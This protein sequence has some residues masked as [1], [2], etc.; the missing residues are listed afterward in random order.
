VFTL[1][2]DQSY[3]TVNSILFFIFLQILKVLLLEIWIE[4]FFEEVLAHQAFLRSFLQIQNLCHLKS[5]SLKGTSE[6]ICFLWNYPFHPI[7]LSQRLIC[8]CKVSSFNSL[9][10][11]IFD[12]WTVTVLQNIQNLVRCSLEHWPLTWFFK[13]ELRLQNLMH[14]WS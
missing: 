2:I 7:C 9:R 14:T 1:R 11:G 8:C 3:G 5:Y 10:K 13:S 6:F 4:P 12:V